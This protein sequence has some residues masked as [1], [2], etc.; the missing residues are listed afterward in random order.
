[1]ESQKRKRRDYRLARKA[2]FTRPEPGFSLY[3][4]RTRGKRIRYTYSDD[5]G[6]SDSFSTRQSNRNS[7]NSTP[8]EPTAPTFTA[9]GR[10]VRSRH[11]GAYG[12]SMRSNKADVLEIRSNGGMEV[13]EKDD[14]NHFVSRSRPRRAAQ[15]NGVQPKPQARKHIE[16]YNSLDSMNDESDAAS[17]GGWECG[18][19]DDSDDHV[20]QDEEDEDVEMSDVEIND[21]GEEELHGQR[22]LVVALRYLKGRSSPPTEDRGADTT[23]DQ[24]PRPRL[25]VDSPNKLP[26][27][28]PTITGNLTS[29]PTVSRAHNIDSNS[30]VS[31]VFQSQTSHPHS[32]PVAT[33]HDTNSEARDASSIISPLESGLPISPNNHDGGNRSSLSDQCPAAGQED[34]S[35]AYPG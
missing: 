18:D 14:E 32:S 4:G 24:S 6:G 12:E 26:A 30:H 31:T 8:V 19:D 20:E 5:E 35:A 27:V 7:R 29:D 17:S 9:S 1:M 34:L 15:H 28:R 3:E 23:K 25:P 2:Q 10:Q 11:G 33:G 16:G 13:A 22:S 21:S